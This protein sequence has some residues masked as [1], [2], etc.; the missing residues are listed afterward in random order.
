M[1]IHG[2]FHREGPGC[3]VRLVLV[4]EDDSEV[5]DPGRFGWLAAMPDTVDP[6]FAIVTP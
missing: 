3:P 4:V 1:G 2:G 6:D 5:T